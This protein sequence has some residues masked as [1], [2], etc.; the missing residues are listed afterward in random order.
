MVRRSMMGG[1][2]VSNICI[3][4]PPPQTHGEANSKTW[5]R[6]LVITVYLINYYSILQYIQLFQNSSAH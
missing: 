3:F 5:Q 4:L 2:N 1:K 6:I